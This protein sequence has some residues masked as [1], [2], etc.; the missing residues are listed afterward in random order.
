MQARAVK[1]EQVEW[2][3]LSNFPLLSD[4]KITALDNHPNFREFNGKSE[5]DFIKLV[6]SK[7]FNG[8]A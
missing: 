5:T 3:V 8:V 7:G 2:V 6:L 1:G 4:G